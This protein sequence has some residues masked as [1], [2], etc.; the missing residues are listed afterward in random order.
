MSEAEINARD[1]EVGEGGREP[2]LF[3][4]S[5]GKDSALALHTVQQAGEY[6]VAALLTTVTE[7]YERVSIH[8]VRRELLAAQANALGYPLEVVYIPQKSSNEVYEQRMLRG[9]ERYKAQ[10]LTRN[11][12]GDIFLE[13]VRAYREEKLCQVGMSGVFPLWGQ[14]TSGLAERFINEGFKAVLTCVD[15][16]A[17]DGEFAGREYDRALLEDL[18]ETVDPCGENGEFHT[19]VYAGPILKRDLRI[20]RGERVLREGR[21]RYCD[22]HLGG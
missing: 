4:W 5:G 10:G 1:G 12:F 8:G 3:A 19:F 13:D 2:V 14:Q 9:L 17:L 7:G 21:F 20:R 22:L 18:P 11:V 15:T 6:E 16:Q